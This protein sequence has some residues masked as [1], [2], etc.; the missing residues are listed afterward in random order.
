[1]VQF[2]VNCPDVRNGKAVNRCE[3]A[4]SERIESIFASRDEHQMR[5]LRRRVI[6]RERHREIINL[7]DQQT[8][9]LEEW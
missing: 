4:V 3:R 1:M 2:R 9:L 6:N 7:M 5:Y 8:P